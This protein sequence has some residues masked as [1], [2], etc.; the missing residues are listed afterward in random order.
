MRERFQTFGLS[1]VR[2]GV[3]VRHRRRIEDVV[4]STTAYFEQPDLEAEISHPLPVPGTTTVIILS[5]QVMARYAGDISMPDRPIPVTP[6]VQLAHAAL[7]ADLRGGIDEAELDARLTWLIGRL[8]E[9]ATPGRLTSRRAVT[10]RSHQRIVAH[11]RE[12]IAADPAALDLSR[13]SAD[14]GHSPFHVSRVFHRATGTT[15]IDH[16][17]QVRVAAAIDR[18]VQ[19]DERFADLAAELGF[20]D[21]SHFARVLRS[22]VGLPPSRLREQISPEGPVRAP[23]SDNDVQDTPVAGA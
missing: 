21:Q 22:S 17:N 15:L 18:I 3:F 2:R 23:R 14:L 13:L 19:G 11:V 7:L 8:V 10:A 12:A 16:R 9:T 6:D 4:D 20:A 5:P 1:F